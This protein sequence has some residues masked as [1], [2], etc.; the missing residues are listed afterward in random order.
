MKRM[1]DKEEI[2]DI[3]QEESPKSEVDSELSETSENPVQNKV[4]TEALG[5]IKLY[6][7]YIYLSKIIQSGTEYVNAECLV[8]TDSETVFN[9]NS[10][11]KY[12]HDKEFSS[13]EKYFPCNAVYINK[14]NS[15]Y[16]VGIYLKSSSINDYILY[17]RL[18]DG[19]FK[20]ISSSFTLSDTVISLI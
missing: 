17:V 1:F 6:A 11:A 4:I 9:N 5:N 7:H 12:L 3:I 16:A 18:P 8:L 19:T 20:Q 15:T 10:F 14:S 2:V 13:G